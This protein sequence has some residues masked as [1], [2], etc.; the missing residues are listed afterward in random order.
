VPFLADVRFGSLADK[1][2]Q[3]KIQRFGLEVDDQLEV[4]RLLDRQIV[5]LSSLENFV[6]ENRGALEVR[7]RTAPRL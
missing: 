2:S 6:D 4:G 3:A 7:E 1:P 5:G